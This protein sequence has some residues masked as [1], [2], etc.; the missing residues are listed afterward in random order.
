MLFS[1][2]PARAENLAMS[3]AR[4]P[5]VQSAP[6]NAGDVFEGAGDFQPGEL[7]V[8]TDYVVRKFLGEGGTPP[9]TSA[10]TGSASESR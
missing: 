5:N 9:P 8:G 6:A 10:R 4:K 7:I 1:L 3:G 2:A